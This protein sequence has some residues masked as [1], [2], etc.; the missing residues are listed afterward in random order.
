ML[1]GL[2]FI[3]AAA[4]GQS[5]TEGHVERPLAGRP[6]LDLRVGGAIG[7]GPMPTVCVEGYPLSRLSLEACGNGS[8]VF[9]G[10]QGGD[11]AHFRARATVA[12]RDV[13]R[14]E[15]AALVGAGLAEIQSAADRPG[16][17]LGQ[18]REP[19]QVEAAG[20][21]ASISGKA[22]VWLSGGSYLVGDVN[23]GAAYV[24]AAPVVVG[25]GGPVVPF[26][27]FTMGLGF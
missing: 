19:A 9:N 14:A 1:S 23:V 6:V 24:P 12:E 25:A 13:G 16:F 8:G 26:A 4:F 15:L 17:L 18:A 7:A 5:E 11:F 10:S 3:G 22:R 2:L 20:A 27:S 21:E